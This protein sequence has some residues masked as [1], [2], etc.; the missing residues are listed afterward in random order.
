[1]EFN[2][3]YSVIVDTY[4]RFL[5][6]NKL[7]KLLKNTGAH[8][9]KVTSVTQTL[10]AILD[11]ESNILRHKT[12]LQTV[13]VNK[14]VNKIKAV[15]AY[16]SYI[17]RSNSRVLLN[18]YQLSEKLNLCHLLLNSLMI[19]DDTDRISSNINLVL[20]I[21]YL[22]CL[23]GP[24]SGINIVI[25]QLNSQFN[26]SELR[27][28]LTT[29]VLQNEIITYARAAYYDFGEVDRIMN[30]HFMADICNSYAIIQQLG[31]IPLHRLHDFNILCFYDFIDDNCI[32]VI[33]HIAETRGQTE[34]LAVF[35]VANELAKLANHPI[36]YLGML[37]EKSI[38][39]IL[40]KSDYNK[41]KLD[42]VYLVDV[43]YDGLIDNK[44]QVISCP[45][46]LRNLGKIIMDMKEINMEIA[47]QKGMS[48]VK[49]AIS[50]NSDETEL[51]KVKRFYKIDG[52]FVNDCKKLQNFILLCKRYSTKIQ[53]NIYNRYEALKIDTHNNFGL[54][55]SIAHFLHVANA[56]LW[57][58]IDDRY[59]DIGYSSYSNAYSSCVFK[60]GTLNTLKRLTT[61][62]LGVTEVR[63]D[64]FSELFIESILK[65]VNV[66]ELFLSEV[67]LQQREYNNLHLL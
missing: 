2:S 56:E 26:L 66:Y 37:R 67:E 52:D 5:K 34:A 9:I 32:S 8:T 16:L 57:H 22:E 27:E 35:I 15:T 31:K 50:C 1:M 19:K 43:S 30:I 23:E 49:C 4:K 39:E 45:Y 53:H 11:Y 62:T 48:L 46:F 12:N 64:M 65:Q 7:N 42:N 17:G 20:T 59:L 55:V 33:E 25:T 61:N 10:A 6:R 63:F 41:L 28:L 29:P 24:T 58:F 51:I 40:T 14:S 21:V 60:K 3:V 54:C 47:I 13:R 38:N 18:W 36:G 44:C